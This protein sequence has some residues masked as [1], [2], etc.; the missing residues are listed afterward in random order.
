[1]EGQPTDRERVRVLY[2]KAYG[3]DPT[4]QETAKALALVQEVMKALRSHEHD[5]GRRLLR[6]WTCLCQVIVSANEFVYLS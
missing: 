6:G 5:A 1:L 3:R 4:P 2:R